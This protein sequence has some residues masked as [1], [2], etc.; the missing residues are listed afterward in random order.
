MPVASNKQPDFKPLPSGSHVARCISVISLGT[1]PANNPQFKDSQKVMLV[2]E[3][4]GE[5]LE[6]DGK[7][8]PMTISKDYTLSLN[9]KSTLRHDLESWRGRAFTEQELAGFAVES[10]L[11]AP[12][13]LSVIHKKSG[14]GKI[15]GSIAG[16]A[17]LP[18]GVECPPQRHPKTHY[19]IEMGQN[20]VF[21]S[22]H[23]WVQKKILACLEWNKP[24]EPEHP[25][26]EEGDD[27]PMG[28]GQDTPF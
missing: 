22:L 8:I 12:C 10:V 11:A 15:Y 27:V 28:D 24:A 25:I 2:W 6:K 20:E 1:Q 3:V 18:K 9:E 23:E 21:K 17:G 14:Q 16:V 5:I 26:A 4:P 13:M 7:R 19:E